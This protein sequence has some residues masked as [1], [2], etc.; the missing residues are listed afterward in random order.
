MTVTNEADLS[1]IL[2]DLRRGSGKTHSRVDISGTIFDEFTKENSF[3][4]PSAG[5]NVPTRRREKSLSES[6]IRD[7]YILGIMGTRRCCYFVQY[8]KYLNI[9]TQ[10]FFLKKI[11]KILSILYFWIGGRHWR[12][13]PIAGNVGSYIDVWWL[14][15]GIFIAKLGND[16]D[17]A[18]PFSTTSFCLVEYTGGMKIMPYAIP[19]SVKKT[20]INFFCG[21]RYVGSKEK[22]P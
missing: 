10:N 4:L 3:F 19:R 13:K 9:A 6:S 17:K 7:V 21:F 11:K 5:W 8:T 14:Q 16:V 1:R 2:V 12:G 15:S 20:T 18:G 22:F